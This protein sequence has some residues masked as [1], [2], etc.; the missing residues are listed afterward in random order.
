MQYN[1]EEKNDETKTIGIGGL[2]A[3]GFA[4]LRPGESGKRKHAYAVGRQHSD[5][6][7]PHGQPLTKL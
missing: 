2:P 6:R 7:C 4:A 5:G 1:N 3:A